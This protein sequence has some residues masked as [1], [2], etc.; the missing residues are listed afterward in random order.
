[1]LKA[2]CQRRWTHEPALQ[3][4]RLEEALLP[5][6]FA[7]RHR[8]ARGRGIAA[9]ARHS[10]LREPRRPSA[11]TCGADVAAAKGSMCR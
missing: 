2:L 11:C 7:G 4:I 3:R 8:H 9:T 5:S 10:S 6:S 1:V